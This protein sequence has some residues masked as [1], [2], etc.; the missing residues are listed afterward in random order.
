MAGLI[1]APAPLVAA[2]PAAIAAA[3]VIGYAKAVPQNIPPHASRIDLSTRTLA[4]P[5]V[6]APAIAPAFTHAVAP[7]VAPAFAPA[8]LAYSPYAFAGNLAAPFV[9]PAVVV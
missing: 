3:P 2:A 6:A 1:P 7:A 8:H 5:Y 9:Q 4:A